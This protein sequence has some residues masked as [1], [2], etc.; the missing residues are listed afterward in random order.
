MGS[1]EK[2]P[3]FLAMSCWLGK[4]TL[5]YCAVGRRVLPICSFEQHFDSVR[6][7]YVLEALNGRPIPAPC[8]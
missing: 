7:H 4:L 3:F 6:L 2:L 1:I 8:R 5:D